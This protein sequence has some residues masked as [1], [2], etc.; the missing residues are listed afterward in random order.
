MHY[1]SAEDILILND[2]GQGRSL[3]ERSL[4][5]INVAFPEK[6]WEE[7]I[8]MPIG[9]RDQFLLAVYEECFGKSIVGVSDCPGCDEEI[10][11]T[12]P[13]AQIRSEDASFE[14]ATV[15]ASNGQYRVRS[16]L[17]DS[18]DLLDIA[19][20]QDLEE[21]RRRLIGRCIVSSRYRGKS[22]SP[23]RLP[24]Y[25]LKAVAESILLEDQQAEILMD[26]HCPA[27]DHAWEIQFD[28]SYH[29]WE[30]LAKSADALFW[31]V[32]VL[33]KAYGWQEDNILSMNAWR[34]HQ[35]LNHVNA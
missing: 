10:E 23:H 18:S 27:C 9:G 25:V 22:I 21:A 30:S 33:A 17:P 13:V 1:L 2:W 6:S 29:F 3:T 34:R 4:A 16:R 14:P 31:E 8:A 32:H 35:Y 24:T 11:M 20:S 26:V 28:I 19:P 7:L 12:V 5:A 15:S